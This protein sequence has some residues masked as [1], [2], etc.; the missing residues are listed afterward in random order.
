ML[1]SECQNE[2]FADR[3]DAITCSNRCRQARHRRRHHRP[4]DENQL[5]ILEMKAQITELQQL[6]AQLRGQRRNI[7]F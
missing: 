3:D 5:R 2:F 4:P 1:C 7:V 6:C